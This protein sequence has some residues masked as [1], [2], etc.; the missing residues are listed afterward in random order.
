MDDGRGRPSFL[1]RR[2]PDQFDVR[3]IVVAPRR[4]RAFDEAEWRDALVVVERGEIE[5]E[6][7]GGSRH[8][9]GS[10]DV[11]WLCGLPLRAL[12]NRGRETALLVAVSRR[13]RV[14]DLPHSENVHTFIDADHGVSV[15]F[16]QSHGFTTTGRRELRI[17]ALLEGM[18]AA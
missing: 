16:I 8:R 4:R 11:L 18:T 12:L 3:R 2:V 13:A 14:N 6:C 5:L 17:A 7:V 10:G 9:F 1:G 15:S